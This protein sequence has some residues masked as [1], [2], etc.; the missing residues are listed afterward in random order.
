MESVSLCKIYILA[1]DASGGLM[2]RTLVWLIFVL[3]LN[4]GGCAHVMSEAGLAG[5]DRSITYAD[6]RT[7]PETL[8]GTRVLVGG[9]IAGTRSSGD[10]MQ[11]EIAQLELLENGV[12]DESS[13]SGGRF[14]IVSG[15][16]LDPLFYRPGLLITVIGEIKGQKIQRLE[17]ADYRYPL[18]SAKE[19]RLF[20]ASDLSS[21]RQANPYQSEF[22]DGRFMLRPPGGVAVEPQAQRP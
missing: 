16:L 22:G 4:L 20:R 6:I 14:L 8:V 5:V 3:A 12:P 17:G 19:L 13:P 21:G 7:R 2:K 1:Y 15:E 11:L 10:F 9:V 18:L